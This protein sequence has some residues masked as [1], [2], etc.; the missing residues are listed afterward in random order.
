MGSFFYTKILEVNL[1]A[2]AY[3]LFHE[4]FF[5]IHGSVPKLTSRIFVNILYIISDLDAG[6]PTNYE[7]LGGTFGVKSISSLIY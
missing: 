3:R 2:F 7:L 1:F 6:F 4:D 5:P